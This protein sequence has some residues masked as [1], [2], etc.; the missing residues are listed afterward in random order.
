M[1]LPKGVYTLRETQP[2]GYFQGGQ[3]A[4]SG[5]GDD[6][7][8]DVI[9]KIPIT[10][11]DRFVEYN[12]HELEPASLSGIVWSETDLN[13][14][15]DPTDTRLAGVTIEL[16]DASG[17]L[18]QTTTTDSSGAYQFRRVFSLAP[19][20]FVSDKPTGLF[21]WK[22]IAGS[23]GGNVTV[24]DLIS[25][26]ELVGGAQ[27]VRYDFAEFPPATISGVVFQDGDSITLAN[28]PNPE[29]LRNFRDG[30]L[31]PGDKPIAGV[32]LELRNVFGRAFT[33]DQAMPGMYPD[34][35]IRAVTAAD[36]TYEFKGLKPW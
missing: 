14:K 22:Q 18:I 26:I 2:V 16:L 25:G 3:C 8:D 24:D 13:S 35:P 31:K 32:V 10:F 9:S 15:L 23:L 5:G 12:F 33:A 7:V 30:I 36:G 11:G 29:D 19:M 27:G 20:R 34:G 1:N 28:A 6:T 17:N 4:G 21:H